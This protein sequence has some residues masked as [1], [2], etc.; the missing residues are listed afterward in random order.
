M[1]VNTRIILDFICDN[2]A[3]DANLTT[4]K[5]FIFYYCMLYIT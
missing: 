2:N 1:F 4:L 5:F 3:K